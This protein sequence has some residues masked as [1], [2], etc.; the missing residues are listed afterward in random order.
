MLTTSLSGEIL[1]T[2]YGIENVSIYFR[3]FVNLG[4]ECSY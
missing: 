4:P 3:L 1:G 2:D